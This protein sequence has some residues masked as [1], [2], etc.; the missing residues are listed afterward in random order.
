MLTRQGAVKVKNTGARRSDSGGVSP[1]ILA[2]REIQIIEKE[3]SAANSSS[4]SLN[5]WYQKDVKG[6]QRRPPPSSQKEDSDEGPP[7]RITWSVAATREKFEL[8]CSVSGEN[9]GGKLTT[10]TPISRKRS[11]RGTQKRRRTQDAA[12]TPRRQGTVRRTNRNTDQHPNTTQEDDHDDKRSWRQEPHTTQTTVKEARKVYEG[13]VSTATYSEEDSQD[14][15]TPQKEKL[16]AKKSPL[17]RTQNVLHDSADTTTTEERRGRGLPTSSSMPA[18]DHDV[19]ICWRGPY[20]AQ[21][22][23]QAVLNNISNAFLAKRRLLTKE[24]AAARIQERLGLLEERLWELQARLATVDQVQ[25]GDRRSVERA[26]Q[27]VEEEV[28]HLNTRLAVVQKEAEQAREKLAS[29]VEVG[30][31][32]WSDRPAATPRNSLTRRAKGNRRRR[33]EEEEEEECEEESA[34]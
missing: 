13:R 17:T 14:D 3:G 18:R 16:T 30:L 2:P 29:A 8:L 32:Q 23:E 21:E 5:S 34:A 27:S 6:T 15:Y 12:G 24:V 33:N 25:S 1:R 28:T 10:K 4:E 9:K 20:I 11:L 31:S 19:V 22:S 26:I 7:S